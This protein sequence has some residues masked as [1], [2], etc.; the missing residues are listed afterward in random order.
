M[1]E[2]EK[3]NF[4]ARYGKHEAII[5]TMNL[6]KACENFIPLTLKYMLVLK[7]V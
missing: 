1:N 2:T 3:P 4:A 5:N 7:V 6:I